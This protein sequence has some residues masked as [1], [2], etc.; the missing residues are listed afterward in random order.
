MSY[1]NQIIIKI[2]GGLGNQLFQF[3]MGKQLESL[4]EGVE[5]L[6]D[7]SFFLDENQKYPREFLLNS[8]LEDQIPL[9]KNN[10]VFAPDW[11]F[12]MY[13]YAVKKKIW[14]RLPLGLRKILF[15]FYV[16][17]TNIIK[18]DFEL[19]FNSNIFTRFDGLKR[20]QS[21]VRLEGYWCDYRYSNLIIQ[22]LRNDL[23]LIQKSEL[24][25]KL[26]ENIG[27]HDIMIHVRRGDYLTIGRGEEGLFLGSNYYK[28]SFSFLE[29]NGF[30]QERCKIWVFSDDPEWC[31]KS[32]PENWP[33]WIY[34]LDCNGLNDVE[35]FELMRNFKHRVLANSTF[36]LWCF[37]L[38]NVK[39]GI[40]V[41]PKN[42]ITSYRNLGF[43]LLPCTVHEI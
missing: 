15:D 22:Q 2:Y 40:T 5:V 37:Y 26:L 23:R 8:F 35:A 3:S 36:S 19:G 32:F 9:N 18:E 7:T 24:Y 43:E 33:G 38:S 30:D 34:E 21:P 27:E 16:L 14:S 12:K 1:N 28:M 4:L 20:Q 11:I 39:N 10:T 41:A 13:K 29:M 25:C 6:F 42:W 17:N 31:R